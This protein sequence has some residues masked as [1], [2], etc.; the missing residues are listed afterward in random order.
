MYLKVKGRYRVHSSVT[1]DVLISDEELRFPLLPNAIP[2]PILITNS[3]G[4]IYYVNAAWEKLTGYSFKEVQG[5]N[6]RILNSGKTDKT[7]Y[8]KLWQ[9]L[10][11]GKTFSTEKIIDRS[12]DG[13]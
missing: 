13:K 4:E 12:K 5:K 3:E 10:S 8:K 11:K 9:K 1:R 2:D 7:I 6:P